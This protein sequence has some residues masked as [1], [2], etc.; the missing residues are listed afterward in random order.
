MKPAA[1][2]QEIQDYCRA[3]ANA[4]KAQK[5]ERYFKEGYDAWGLLD[6][7]D[8]LWHARLNEW[9]TKYDALGLRGFFRAGELLFASGKFE[10]GS[11][12]IKFILARRDQLDA[13]AVKPLGKWFASGLAN[14]GHADALCSE[15]LAPLVKS[16]AVTMA[17]L[18]PWRQSA[19]PYQRR[20]AAV[21]FLGLAKRGGHTAELLEFVRPLMSD[22]NRFVQQGVGWLLREMWK[23]EPQPVEN[24]LLEFKDTAPRKIFQ[25]ATERMTAEQKVRFK[26]APQKK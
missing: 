17:A 5:W 11:L 10:E 25:Y 7:D 15:I 23:K 22:G 4:E 6:R 2:V 20:A 1:L 16:G 19:H 24:F 9:S 3:H 8:P 21:A 12:A 18:A 13:T 14:W 26:K